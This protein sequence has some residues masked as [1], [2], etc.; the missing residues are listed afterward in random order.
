ME[1]A[2]IFAVAIFILVMAVIISE[3]LHRATV[4]WPEESS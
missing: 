1:T 4:A 3:K 2:Q